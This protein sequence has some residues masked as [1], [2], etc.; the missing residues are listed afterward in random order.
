[1]EWVVERLIFGVSLSTLALLFLI[2][3]FVGREALPILFGT[4]NSSLIQPVI[5]AADLDRIPPGELRAYL[6]MTPA[7]FRSMDRETLRAI[8]KTREEALEEVPPSFRQDPDARINTTE[9]RHLILPRRW[10]G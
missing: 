7:E 1:L 6:G 2:V 5:P 9:W 8:M 3:V 4:A 10:T